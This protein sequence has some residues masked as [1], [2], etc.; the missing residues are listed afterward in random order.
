MKIKK[1]ILKNYIIQNL[2]ASILAIYIY[3]VRST[4]IFIV[5][6][7]KI[8]KKYWETNKPFIMTFWHS[9]LMMISFAWKYKKRIN[10]LASGHSDGRFGSIVGKYFHLNNIPTY[11]KN[12]RI[13]LKPI[14]ELIKNNNFIG[15]TPDGPRGPKEQ[16]T[17]GIIKI[18]KKTKI[19][20]IPIGFWS[21]KNI[22]LSSWDSFLV[23]LPF[24][25]C[26]F[27]WNDPLIIPENL[28]D[29]QIKKY[30]KI[31]ESEIKKSIDKA[32]KNCK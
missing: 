6:N 29:N 27:V 22:K 21:S 25:K 1:K 7:E 11:D 9:Q 20:I 24:S 26:S 30:Q 14:F 32:K 10:I 23:T 8:P 28:N 18:A 13:S 17:E 16:V 12:K 4:S 19:P 15:I 2:L 31:L 3:F 5:E